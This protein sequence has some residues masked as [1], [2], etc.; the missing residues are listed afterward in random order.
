MG[1]FV[2]AN[3]R[4]HNMDRFAKTCGTRWGDCGITQLQHSHMAEPIQQVKIKKEKKTLYYCDMDTLLRML[5][6]PYLMKT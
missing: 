3:A 1:R 6:K 2:A 4:I 5:T